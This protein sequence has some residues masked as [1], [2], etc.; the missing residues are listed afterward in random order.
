MNV[1]ANMCAQV[2]S[3]LLK[4]GVCSNLIVLINMK[5]IPTLLWDLIKSGLVLI[6]MVFVVV[7]ALF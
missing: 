3:S 7:G 5:R 6:N 1:L 2:L 4:L